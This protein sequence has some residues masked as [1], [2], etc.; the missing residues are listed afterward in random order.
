MGRRG[1]ESSLGTHFKSTSQAPHLRHQLPHLLR[2][3]HHLWGSPQCLHWGA[4][5]HPPSWPQQPNPLPGTDGEE[6]TAWAVGPRG[7]PPALAL[8]H[9]QNKHSWRDKD[10]A[11]GGCPGNARWEVWG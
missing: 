3:A 11:R 10:H 6:E 7:R 4:L 1:K 5:H 2:A 8:R 9:A